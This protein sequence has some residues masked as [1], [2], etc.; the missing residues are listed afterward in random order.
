ML[1]LPGREGQDL[2][3]R[4]VDPVLVEQHLLDRADDRFVVGGLLPGLEMGG[5]QLL[6]G[7]GCS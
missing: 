1:H 6:L 4:V 2:E 5:E 7:A 3:R